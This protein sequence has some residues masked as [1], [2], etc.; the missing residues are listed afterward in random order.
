VI[1]IVNDTHAD[2]FIKYSGK[3]GWAAMKADRKFFQCDIF[4]EVP[5]QIDQQHVGEISIGVRE[6]FLAIGTAIHSRYLND[7]IQEMGDQG[8]LPIHPLFFSLLDHSIQGFGDALALLWVC[9]QKGWRCFARKKNGPMHKV[10][11]PL[12]KRE[13]YRVIHQDLAIE[14]AVDDLEILGVEISMPDPRPD[15]QDVSCDKTADSL[16]G[17]MLGSPSFYQDKLMK[18]MFVV[19]SV[20][21]IGV[22]LDQDGITFLVASSGVDGKDLRFE[23]LKSAEILGN[24]HARL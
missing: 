6:C 9:V 24:F 20:G 19:I 22:A 4:S 1:D 7:E 3:M 2:A 10:K 13:K 21:L 8:S 18:N 15:D 14:E 11:G 16:A 23:S 12:G 5:F 17:L